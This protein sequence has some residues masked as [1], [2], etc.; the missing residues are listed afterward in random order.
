MG[1]W[2]QSWKILHSWCCAKI[3]KSAPSMSLWLDGAWDLNVIGCWMLFCCRLQRPHELYYLH[4]SVHHPREPGTHTRWWTGLLMGRI[5]EWQWMHHYLNMVM[6]GAGQDI[7]SDLLYLLLSD[8][9]EVPEDAGA[10]GCFLSL[11]LPPKLRH[12]VQNLKFMRK[13][14]DMLWLISSCGVDKRQKQHCYWA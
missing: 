9:L 6:K 10:C 4:R 12:V 5:W 13:F 14:E 11:N 2:C 7:C 3:L 8:R 1:C